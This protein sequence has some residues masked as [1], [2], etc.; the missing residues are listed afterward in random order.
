MSKMN[1]TELRRR[2]GLL[3]GIEPSPQAT[4]RALA[5]VRRTLIQTDQQPD[6]RPASRW[7]ILTKGKMAGLAAAAIIVV[8]LLLASRFSV[9]LDGTTAAYARVTEAVRKVPWMRI[10]YSGYLL[11]DAGNRIT[12]EG[13]RDDE[14]WYSFNAQVMI[15]RNARGAIDYY[16]YA[17]QEIHEYNPAA[18]RVV[19]SALPTG[20]RP[21]RPDSP[22]GWL[23]KSIEQITSDGGSVARR[24]GQYKG[25]E[26]EIFEITSA[27]RP[28]VAAIRST[29]FVDRTTSL[30]IAE[31]R[32]YI[33]TNTGNPQLVETGVFDY[34]EQGPADIYGLGLSRDIPTISSLPMPPWSDVRM[35]YESYRF[36]PPAQRYVTV[37]AREMIGLVESVEICY[38]DGA[39]FRKEQHHLYGRGA[40][41]PQWEEQKAEFGDTL[42][43]IL[44]WS[45]AYKTYGPISITI[46]E[47][48]RW[49]D[50]RRDENGAW[51]TTMQTSR[52]RGLT[53]EDS[54]NMC[55]VAQ[56]GGP[57]IL[58]YADI[59]QDDFARENGLIRV[60]GEKGVFYLNPE[61]DYIC[62]Q[63]MPSEG[64]RSTVLEFGRTDTGR[65][66]P[67]RIDNHALKYT[68]YLETNPEFPEGIFDPN[69][70]PKADR[71]AASV[72]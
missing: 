11:D 28:G 70:L 37:V 41:G 34:P 20:R 60:D 56:L 13:E 15:Y 55:P 45:R 57:Q 12:A 14:V 31:E 16:D 43:S 17:R 53:Q 64:Q 52:G 67:K 30:P 4:G 29:V 48:N 18:K 25:Q 69:S 58:G 63:Q 42:E 40:I 49:Y 61:R 36:K 66:Y 47:E 44:K 39:R 1:E 6:A 27:V 21:L 9:P 19:V 22:G 26:T 8:V 38:A 50:S 71:E 46:F 33:N 65:W 5:R 23:E 35:T 54:W 62:Q 10:R 2:L 7:G 32:S 68:V 24:R 3:A 51:R 59:I 72:P